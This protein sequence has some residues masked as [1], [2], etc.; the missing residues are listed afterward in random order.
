MENKKKLSDEIE[1]LREKM[2]QAKEQNLQEEK[3]IEIS[4]KLDRLIVSYLKK[5]K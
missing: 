5:N 3:I 1:K 4:Q 2:I